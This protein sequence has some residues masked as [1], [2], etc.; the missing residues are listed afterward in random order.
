MMKWFSIAFWLIVIAIVGWA[1]WDRLPPQH[2]PFAEL[3]IEHPL[4]LATSLKIAK[5]DSDP[6]AC[7]K[8]LDTSRIE[9]TQLENDEPAQNCGFYNALTLDR[10]ALPYNATLRMTCPLTAALSV[11]ERQALVIRA[12]QYFE[13]PPVKV[14]TFGSYS[15]RRMY[16][17]SSGKYSEHATGNAIDIQGIEFADGSRIILKDDWGTDTPE[18]RFLEDLRND[19][20]RIF[21]TVLGPEYNTAHADHFHLDM[22][23]TGVCS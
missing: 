7:F 19:S 18:G 21:G 12:Q 1:S 10:S 3:S 20:C 14:L 5:F 13:A 11:W 6:D 23:Q 4:G 16:G 8:Y 2:N 15:C 9:Y 17:R 22:S